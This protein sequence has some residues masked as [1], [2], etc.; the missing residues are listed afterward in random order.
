VG[1]ERDPLCLVSTIEELLEGKGSGSGLEIRD[2]GRRGSAAL[3]LKTLRNMVNGGRVSPSLRIYCRLRSTTSLLGLG[4]VRPK[5]T[6]STHQGNI[7]FW[8]SQT[9]ALESGQPS[10]MIDPIPYHQ[11]SSSS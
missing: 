1:L 2:Y 9:C 4:S 5:T 3:V 10:Q 8:P 7:S 6:P 11:S